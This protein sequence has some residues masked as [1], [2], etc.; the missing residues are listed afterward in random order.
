MNRKF[1]VVCRS[2]N[3]PI[4]SGAEKHTSTL[5]RTFSAETDMT[6]IRDYVKK[7]NFFNHIIKHEF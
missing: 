6:D 2:G 5:I 1:K 4:C 7:T 3:I